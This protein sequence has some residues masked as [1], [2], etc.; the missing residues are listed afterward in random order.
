MG[1]DDAYIVCPPGVE[2]LVAHEMRALGVEP[3]GTET[4]GVHASL[5]HGDL[6]RLALGLRTASRVVIRMGRFRA[7]DFK[8]L[9]RGARA[10][11]WDR[12]SRPGDPVRIQVSSRKSR[13][14]H[15]RAIAE[16][17]ERAALEAGRIA[18][19]LEGHRPS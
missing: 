18:P 7:R 13:L 14:Y 5:D 10:L 9:E 3:T 11:P 15:Q 16:R 12:F 6:M 4:G 2:T 8:A 1:P 17:V 19:G